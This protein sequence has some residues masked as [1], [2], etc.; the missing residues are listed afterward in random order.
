M[1][2]AGTYKPAFDSVIDTLATI[3]EQRDAAYNE[4]LDS[5]GQTCIEKISDRG[6]RNIAKNPRLQAWQD[7]NNTALAYWRECGLSPGSLRKISAE[8][9]KSQKQ[10]TD[11]ISMLLE[12]I[13]E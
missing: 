12:K 1:E 4:F 2:E 6:A 8:E 13:T 3:L 11:I 10:E 7:L 9:M 5:G